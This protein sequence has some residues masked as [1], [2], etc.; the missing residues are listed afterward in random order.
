MENMAL[1]GK[2]LLL[3]AF[4]LLII[5]VAFNRVA[6]AMRWL[7][8]IAAAGM[9]YWVTV[10]VKITLDELLATIGAAL[11]FHL[12]RTRVKADNR[13]IASFLAG[14]TITVLLVL[15]LWPKTPP[16]S[17]QFTPDSLPPRE[18]VIQPPSISNS[19]PGNLGYPREELVQVIG[20]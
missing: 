16:I 5:S 20:P 12:W 1:I 2:V 7:L 14:I 17:R 4:W 9:L 3:T 19:F 6:P 15:L 8:V 11:L 13:T 18:E 10:G